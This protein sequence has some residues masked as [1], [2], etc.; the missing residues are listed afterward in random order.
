MRR[1][2][3]GPCVVAGRAPRPS[4]DARMY[5]CLIAASAPT[6]VH[7]PHTSAHCCV[8]VPLAYWGSSLG[9]RRRGEH[10][11][12]WG[13]TLG[14]GTVPHMPLRP[15]PDP[16]LTHWLTVRLSNT[17]EQHD[18]AGAVHAK[19]L[20]AA[21]HRRPVCRSRHRAPSHAVSRPE[22][23][24]AAG[25]NR[26][27]SGDWVELHVAAVGRNGELRSVGLRP[28]ADLRPRRP[29]PTPGTRRWQLPGREATRCT[30][31]GHE[32]AR[33]DRWSRREH[34]DRMTDLRFVEEC[35]QR[36][37]QRGQS[38]HPLPIVSVEGPGFG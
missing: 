34:S 33:H 15:V 23:V 13:R 14:G 28:R 1:D 36:R 12:R 19:L 35:C 9:F 21:T 31:R 17:S 3:S 24:V 7:R 6:V 8:V 32:S 20:V 18:M 5:S 10:S 11:G 2:W 37:R 27:G 38:L 16:R 30:G 25:K 29:G 4:Q 26:R 22:T